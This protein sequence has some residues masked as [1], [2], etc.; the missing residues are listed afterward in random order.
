MTFMKKRSY[1]L[2]LYYFTSIQKLFYF[3][4]TFVYLC[5]DISPVFQA[6]K[7]VI[8]LSI[9]VVLSCSM[10]V[11]LA[12]GTSRVLRGEVYFLHLIPVFVMSILQ[13]LIPFAKWKFKVTPKSSKGGVHF[14]YWIMPLFV[15][16][17]SVAAVCAGTLKYIEGNS[18]SLGIVF[19]TAAGI[20]YAMISLAAMQV[21]SK[22]PISYTTNHFFDFLPLR[23]TQVAQSREVAEA[24]GVSFMISN[25]SVHFLHQGAIPLGE[26]IALEL[27][28]PSKRLNLSGAIKR[29]EK[30]EPGDM[31]PL[32]I[33]E[34]RL[35]SLE[36]DASRELSLY[37]FEHATPRA[38]L[39]A[40]GFVGKAIEQFV[41]ART[42]KNSE[43]KAL[44]TATFAPVK[45]QTPGEGGELFGV[46]NAIASTHATLRLNRALE[47][48]EEVR[49]H[50]PWSQSDVVAKVESALPESWSPGSAFLIDV[51]FEQELDAE[52]SYLSKMNR[53][54]ET[55]EIRV[56]IN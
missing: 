34:V 27:D 40:P 32:Y 29:C 4:G 12:R 11:I 9:Y 31:S 23:I 30:W 42:A 22:K 50:L 46:V 56:R 15:F 49:I 3:T 36:V 18:T 20:Y 7:T 5:L 52:F 55:G 2:S 25:E 28:L 16:G 37:Y 44:K 41:E 53:I 54:F 33:V 10:Y 35:E 51:N 19:T 21:L 17:L 39:S 14:K 6:D 8:P 13:G 24:F 38:V 45:V 1:L 26:T 43:I 47:I 48:G